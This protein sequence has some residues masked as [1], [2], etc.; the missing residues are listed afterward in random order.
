MPSFHCLFSWLWRFRTEFLNVLSFRLRTFPWSSFAHSLTHPS[1]HSPILITVIVLYPSNKFYFSFF[2]ASNLI[3]VASFCFLP[4]NILLFL[5]LL[6]NF[7]IVVCQG[8]STPFIV[9]LLLRSKF[10][11]DCF[12]ATK[13]V[14]ALAR[15][16]EQSSPFIWFCSLLTKQQIGAPSFSSRGPLIDVSFL[17][18]KL[19]G[20]QSTRTIKQTSEAQII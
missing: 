10:S 17:G 19:L 14:T 9:K 20:I 15:K 18:H 7:I 5:C 4:I 13:F 8:R 3:V 16:R 1:I 11:L 12:Q 2:A 6:R